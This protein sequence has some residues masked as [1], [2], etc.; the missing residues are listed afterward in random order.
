[1]ERAAE[2]RA[3]IERDGR[4]VSDEMDEVIGEF[5]VES[6]EALDRLDSDLLALEQDPSSR[7]I[8]SS[9]FRAMHTIKGT[10][11]FLGFS[12]L[13]RVAHAAENLLSVLRDGKQTVTAETIDSLLRST[14]AVRYQ[15]EGIERDGAEPEE[16][17]VDLRDWLGRLQRGELGT[18]PASLGRPAED[19]ATAAAEAV[20]DETD[21]TAETDQA[22]H[23]DAAAAPAPSAA[24][25]PTATSAPV[26][27]GGTDAAIDVGTDAGAD[28]APS[29]SRPSGPRTPSWSPSPR[30]TR[31]VQR[32]PLRCPRRPRSPRRWPRR[33]H[34]PVTA[35]RSPA[36]RAAGVSARCSSSVAC[37]TPRASPWRSTSSAWAT[38]AASVRSSSPS[39]C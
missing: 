27:A 7:E 37:S 5:L 26:M 24:A 4:S 12:Y 34:R 33:R 28:R 23:V 15:L 13:E 29:P 8:I 2:G 9:I 30:T 20:N 6:R 19:T 11:G 3:A 14:D 18:A 32:R 10:C 17:H 31:R 39:G 16:E 38:P 1:M 25:A 22:H 21:H 36:R 35:R